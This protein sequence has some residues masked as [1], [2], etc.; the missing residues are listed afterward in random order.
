MNRFR[1]L[2][3]YGGPL[4]GALAGGWLWNLGL[5]GGACWTAA[6]TTLCAAWWVLEPVPM[7]V[8]ALIPFAAFPLTGVLNHREVAHS[9][10]H[11][12]V[13]LMLAG[14]MVGTALERSGAHRRLALGMAR[15]V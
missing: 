5:A 1:R 3:L 11:T 13:L 15:A 12:L 6:I 4:L 8:T 2:A 9:Y 14:S 10:G 7:P